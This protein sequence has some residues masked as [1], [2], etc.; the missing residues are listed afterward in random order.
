MALS[1]V[2]P[3]YSQVCTSECARSLK[4][5]SPQSIFGTLLWSLTD[6]CSAVKNLNHLMH[7][8]LAKVKQGDVLPSCFTSHI[9]NSVFLAI[10]LLPWFSHFCPFRW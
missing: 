9:V 7:K 2:D 8:F 10:Y 3:H 6:T 5:V 1:T 4:F